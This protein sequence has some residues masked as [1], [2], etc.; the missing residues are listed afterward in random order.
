MSQLCP[1]CVPTPV[2]PHAGRK[3]LSWGQIVC[4]C[5]PVG[6][7]HTCAPGLGHTLVFLILE[8][9]LLLPSLQW[10]SLTA[11]APIPPQQETDSSHHRFAKRRLEFLRRESCKLGGT[12]NTSQTPKNA[13]GSLDLHDQQTYS[14][15]ASPC[16]ASQLALGLGSSLGLPED[17][18]PFGLIRLWGGP[19]LAWLCS[20]SLPWPRPFRFSQWSSSCLRKQTDRWA[21]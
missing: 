2:A 18:M 12:E 7:R 17:L 15:W 6:L 11:P 8:R 16:G 5:S 1:T 4:L 14:H 20:V 21:V 19:G 9:W 10:S 3:H 13:A